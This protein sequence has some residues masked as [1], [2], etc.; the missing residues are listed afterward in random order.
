[1]MH[2]PMNIKFPLSEHVTVCTLASN[3]ILGSELWGYEDTTSVTLRE[4]V[5]E[6]E[7]T[8]FSSN[9]CLILYYL[10]FVYRE[11]WQYKYCRHF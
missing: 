8:D 1:M 9:I 11:S 3:R 7:K 2:G 10:L 6:G 4:H 5:K